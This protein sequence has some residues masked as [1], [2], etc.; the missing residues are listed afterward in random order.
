MSSN[1]KILGRFFSEQ[2]RQNYAYIT[3]EN[4]TQLIIPSSRQQYFRT[5]IRHDQQSKKKFPRQLASQGEHKLNNLENKAQ[6]NNDLLET[7]TITRAILVPENQKNNVVVVSDIP[8]YTI[9]ETDQSSH[10][11]MKTGSQR[12]RWNLLFNFLV[13]LI[14]PL[15]FWIPFVFNN[16]TYYLLPCIQVIA[17]LALK[18][19]LIL[20]LN[21]SRNFAKEYTTY[22]KIPIR[23]IVAISC[24]KE[25]VDLIARSVQ[26]LA[27][28]TE[29]HRIIMVISFEQ[30][31]P[32]KEKKCQFL[33]EKFQN[34]G[35]ER[36]IFTIH[37]YGLPNE[38]P[39]KCSNSNYGLRMAVKE[40]NIADDEM[41][42]ILVTTC[43]ADSKFPPQ[44]IAA[45]TNKYLTE[46]RPALSTIYQ[47]PLFYNWKLDGL[48]FVTRV[49]GLLRSFLML[50]ALIPF[51]INTMSIFSFSLSLAKK[52][53]FVHPGYQMDD[54]ICLIRWMG[55]TQQRL[56][57]S[58]IPVPVLS[59]PTSGETIEK[60][61][62]EWARQARRW[63]IGAAE[64]FHYF[65]I[66]ARRMP[67]IAACSWGIT[68]IIYYG[69]LLCTGGLF[70]LTTTLSMTLLIKN[71]PP[72]ITYVMYG[73]LALQMLT[74][75]IAF[76]IDAFIPKLMHVDE[77]IFIPRNLFHFITTP[78]VLL[79]YSF[80]EFYALHEVVIF[81]KK[82]CKHG[83][84][85]KPIL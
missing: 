18:N 7:S 32:D 65:V 43:D 34:C 83:A 2:G 24:Y 60:E 85:A 46:N 81:G 48:S 66:K 56:R 39:G 68:F 38:I 74:F 9:V 79:G 50:G 40:M 51:N 58:M 37:P 71:V 53:D 76:L 41:D 61:I 42:N 17:I 73:L 70:G 45:L 54:I 12:F 55:V 35:F 11:N 3:E 22:E 15:P 52:G 59:G 4:E 84:S 29:V 67:K 5:A 10:R 14:V 30:R 80:V 72:V 25:P 8:Q 63:T 6:H 57:I 49:T 78:F 20:Y 26:T 47:S 13:W 21:H 16:L 1:P 77:C 28:Q 36:M 82:V 62:I 64:V 23:H 27:D 31:T 44:Y 19:S 33:Q 69:I 75:S